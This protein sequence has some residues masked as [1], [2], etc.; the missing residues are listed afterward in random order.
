MKVLGVT[1]LA[2]NV[3]TR[4]C[5][6]ECV[7]PKKPSLEL[8]EC[9]S[10]N[11]IEEMKSALKK[12]DYIKIRGF[13]SL[14]VKHFKERSGCRNPMNPTKTYVMPAK[15]KTVFRCAETFVGELNAKDD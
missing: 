6:E 13:G 15:Y 14:W 11:L 3:H 9:I 1:H 10:F 7:A 2:R 8:I 5:E 12:G 4:C